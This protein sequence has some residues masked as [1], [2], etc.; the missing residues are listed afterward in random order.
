MTSNEIMPLLLL[1]FYTYT[2]IIAWKLFQGT[3]LSQ[4][5][6]LMCAHENKA[7]VQASLG[8]C[9]AGVESLAH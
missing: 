9:Q 4:R 3:N 8:E 6:L 1:L 5:V 2:H 7:T